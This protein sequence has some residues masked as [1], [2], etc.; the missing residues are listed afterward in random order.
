MKGVYAALPPFLTDEENRVWGAFYSA[1]SL[2]LAAR[3]PEKHNTAE[4]IE[5]KITY[6]KATR[7]HEAHQL[8][9]PHSGDYLPNSI[10]AGHSFDEKAE[11][12]YHAAREKHRDLVKKAMD[13]NS[14]HG[15]EQR[16]SVSRIHGHPDD[17]KHL[18]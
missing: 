13:H 17:F 7:P 1:I 15:I 9:N 5:H 12:E 6:A 18:N 10:H 4:W 3:F 11:K 8:F 2:S 16:V 14:G